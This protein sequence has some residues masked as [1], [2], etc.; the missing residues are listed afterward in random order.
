VEGSSAG[1]LLVEA[2][3]P[4]GATLAY[5]ASWA[6][7]QAFPQPPLHSTTRTWPAGTAATDRVF[8]VGL[9]DALIISG[10]SQA[11]LTEIRLADGTPVATLPLLDGAVVAPPQPSDA[12]SVRILDESGAE[13]VSAP[14]TR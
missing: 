9:A 10:P 8:A 6:D 2:R 14:I 1:A 3:F 12:D 11:A 5:A 4:S 7:P 13:L